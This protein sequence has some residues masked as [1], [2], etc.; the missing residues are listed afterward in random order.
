[1]AISTVMTS[2]TCFMLGKVTYARL[3]LGSGHRSTISASRY[4]DFTVW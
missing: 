3:N 1:M 2:R 4:G